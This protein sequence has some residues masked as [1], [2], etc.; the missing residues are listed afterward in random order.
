LALKADSPT[1]APTQ[2]KKYKVV[3]HTSKVKNPM[4]EFAVSLRKQSQ[5]TWLTQNCFSV[6][7][8]VVL[9]PQTEKI[10]RVKEASAFKAKL[11]SL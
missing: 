11:P 8:K 1:C 7:L 3:E 2:V 6:V 5:G 4:I 9:K 10:R